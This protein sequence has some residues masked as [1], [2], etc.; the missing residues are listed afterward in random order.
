MFTDTLTTGLF[1]GRTLLLPDDAAQRPTRNRIRQAVFNMLEARFDLTGARVLDACCGSGAW[2]LEALSRGAAQVVLLDINTATAQ[3]N[4]HAL[5]RP[6]GVDIVQ[7]SAISY[8]PS[9]LFDVVLAD[10]PYGSPVLQNLLQR[11]QLLGRP[12]AVWAVEYGAA[13]QPDF[14]GFTV[15]KTQRYGVSA[16]SLLE[17]LA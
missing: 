13:E 11:R 14:A 15:L 4:W 17:Q 7:A 1:K 8:T 6:A 12:G 5:G 16:V 3:A 10:P 2:G 9:N